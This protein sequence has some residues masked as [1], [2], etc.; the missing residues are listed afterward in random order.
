MISDLYAS[1]FFC[2]VFFHGICGSYQTQV[3]LKNFD[4]ELDNEQL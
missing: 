4:T 3:F 1:M 2:F